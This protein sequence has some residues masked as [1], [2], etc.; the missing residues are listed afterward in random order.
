MTFQKFYA[1]A[2]LPFFLLNPFWGWH[3][4]TAAP[5]P[6]PSPTTQITTDAASTTEW[7]IN[8]TATSSNEDV[9]VTTKT[10]KGT[11]TNIIHAP[12]G[13]KSE[14]TDLNGITTATTTPL[15]KEEIQQMQKQDDAFQKEMDQMW[16]DQ[17]KWFQDVWGSM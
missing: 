1:S 12:Y 15:T 11:T 3:F 8:T 13:V 16:Q 14:I 10:D 5:P 6:T 4:F 2:L 17:E 9:T 7:F